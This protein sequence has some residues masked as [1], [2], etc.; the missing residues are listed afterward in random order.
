MA[1]HY[2]RQSRVRVE[3]FTVVGGLGLDLRAAVGQGL[4]MDRVREGGL[5]CGEVDGMREVGHAVRLV[6]FEDG[7]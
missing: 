5:L 2:R 6:H 1:W 3:I 4:Q 7:P